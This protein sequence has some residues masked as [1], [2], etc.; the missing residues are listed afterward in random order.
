MTFSPRVRRVAL[1]AHVSA[2]VGWLGAVFGALVLAIAARFTADDS[3]T[4]SMF[5]ALDVLARFGLVP[6]AAAALLTGV[7]MSLGTS[8]GLVR[9]YWVV[10]KL[11]LTLAATLVLLAYTGT[12]SALSE[13]ASAPPSSPDA[14][15]LRTNSVIIHSVGALVV[16][17]VA[18]VLAVFKPRGLTRYG[19]RK[20]RQPG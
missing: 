14:A 8:W 5:V 18:N 9:H 20:S 3:A 13:T 19:W 7:L 2:S 12:L 16:L 11:G 6:L 1:T 10:V 15:L 17:F 4:R